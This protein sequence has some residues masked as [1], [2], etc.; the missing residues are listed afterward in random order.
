MPPF[1]W[2][3]SVGEVAIESRDPFVDVA[4]ILDVRRL[5]ARIIAKTADA[6]VKGDIAVGIHQ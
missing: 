6:Q 4:T 2:M 1:L 5:I 3:K